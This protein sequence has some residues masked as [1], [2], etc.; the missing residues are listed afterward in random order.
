MKRVGQERTI[1][2]IFQNESVN[3]WDGYYEGAIFIEF[4]GDL[5]GDKKPDLILTRYFETGGETFFMLSSEAE[6][7]FELK[8]IEKF[9]W[10]CC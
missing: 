4:M 1:Q 10:G 6:E 3:I 7:G 9:Y 5:D 8:L 2:P